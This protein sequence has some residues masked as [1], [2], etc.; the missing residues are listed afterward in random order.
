MVKRGGE[1]EEMVKKWLWNGIYRK[2][3]C[4]REDVVI[5]ACDPSIF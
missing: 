1:E 5:V 3:D 2:D 4:V